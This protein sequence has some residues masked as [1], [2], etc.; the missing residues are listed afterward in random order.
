MLTHE[1]YKNTKLEVVM[2]IR[3]DST[4]EENIERITSLICAKVAET[5]IKLLKE[6]KRD[7]KSQVGELNK[8][9]DNAERY[10]D[11]HCKIKFDTIPY[12]GEKE[13]EK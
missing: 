11:S 9:I 13:A 4:R 5:R 8:D 7:L 2:N 3:R 6:V 10:Y 12:K 1:D